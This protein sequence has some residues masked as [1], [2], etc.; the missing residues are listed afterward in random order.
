MSS[1]IDFEPFKTYFEGKLDAH[2]ATPQG[3]DWNSSASQNLRF[4]Q[5]LKVAEPDRE[6]S[7]IDYGCGYGALASWLSEKG[8]AYRYLGYDLSAAMIARAQELFKDDPR[9]IFTAQEAD[10]PPA[11]YVVACGI[12][13]L[14]LHVEAEIWTEYV[15]QTL[16]KM[17]A[18]CNR[19]LAF[20][21]LTSYSDPERMRPD[22]YYPDPCFYFDLCKRRFSRNVAL[23]HDYNFYDFTIIVRKN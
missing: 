9:C 22:L 13:N 21:M 12:F 2:G 6:F 20:N 18:L 11:D 1:E 4:D 8:F 5:L 7:I 17:N 19:G 10:L 3:V 15:I 16:E 23:L 14:K